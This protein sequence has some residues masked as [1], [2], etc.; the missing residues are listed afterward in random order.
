M[1]VL[2]EELAAIN[3]AKYRKSQ[4]DLQDAEERAD[5]AEQSAT[6][7]RSK[8]RAATSA[9]PG[10]MLVGSGSLTTS[11]SA[12][13]GLGSSSLSPSPVRLLVL[14]QIVQVFYV[15]VSLYSTIYLQYTYVPVH[16]ISK[17][18]EIQICN[19]CWFGSLGCGRPQ[20]FALAA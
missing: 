12:H 3:L 20:A 1:H 15:H 11:F 9:T 16:K 4:G 13:A 18:F 8:S 2:Q 14:V 10:P 7:L 5:M 6:K 19:G 17:C